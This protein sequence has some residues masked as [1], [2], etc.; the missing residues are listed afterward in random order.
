YHDYFNIYFRQ[1]ELNNSKNYKTEFR[2]Y[3]NL[4]QHNPVNSLQKKDAEYYLRKWFPGQIGKLKRSKGW[5]DQ[6]IRNNFNNDFFSAYSGSV[7]S[8][9]SSFN[10]L[11]S[12]LY[13]STMN[14]D[15]QILLRYADRNSM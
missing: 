10:D 11:N 1:L 6:K 14:G 8:A 12:S 4:H 7:F 15:L 13:N 9:E 2:S 3:I 5:L